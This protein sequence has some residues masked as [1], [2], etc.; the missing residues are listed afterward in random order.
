MLGARAEPNLAEAYSS[1]KAAL[2][3]F[4]IA[5]TA[6]RGRIVD[7]AKRRSSCCLSNSKPRC[8][9]VLPIFRCG[10]EVQQQH[11]MLAHGVAQVLAV[12][13]TH[14]VPKVSAPPRARA[15]IGAAS[16]PSS[17]ELLAP[18]AAGA[19]CGDRPELQPVRRRSSGAAGAHDPCWPAGARS[20]AAHSPAATQQPCI[21]W[22][23]RTARARSRPRCTTTCSSSTR[24]S[25]RAAPWRSSR[26]AAGGDFPITG[27]GAGLEGVAGPCCSP[28]YSCSTRASV[29]VH[30]RR[31]QWCART[32]A[33]SSCASRWTT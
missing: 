4:D 9:A 14:K 12:K 31:C 23:R 6:P 18:L 5:P 2:E 29:C 11:P 17:Q 21:A 32:R 30:K 7:S 22:Q 26:R 1:W 33:P 16:A 27:Q 24:R 28:R 10:A 20:T 25:P 13:R 19:G 3:C 15:R 8:C